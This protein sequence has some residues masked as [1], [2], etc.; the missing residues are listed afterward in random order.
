[1]AKRDKAWVRQM[2]VVW[3]RPVFLGRHFAVQ[4][5]ALYYHLDLTCSPLV[6]TKECSID[7][8]VLMC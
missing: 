1:M 7:I 6:C 5:L 2:A 8:D 4:F 3:V